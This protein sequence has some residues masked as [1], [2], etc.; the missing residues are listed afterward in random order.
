MTIFTQYRV[1]SP[2]L[3]ELDAAAGDA[4]RASF[5]QSFQANPWFAIGRWAELR[6]A[7][8]M[9]RGDFANREEFDRWDPLREQLAE[10]G[11]TA[12]E[13]PSPISAEDARRQVSELGLDL[14]I[15]EEGIYQNV[16]DI[17]IERKRAERRRLDV[18]NRAPAGLGNASARL[19]VGLG[20]SLLDPLNIASGFIPVVGPARYAAL[21]G[22]AGNV[23]SRAGVRAGVGV[24]EGTVGAALV[25]PI[26]YGAMRAEQSDYDLVDSLLNIT[27]GGVLGGGLHVVGGTVMDIRA[28]RRAAD[29]PPPSPIERGVEAAAPE[30]REAGLRT[31][32]AQMATGRNVNVEPV[33]NLDPVVRASQSEAPVLGIAR[34]LPDGT[35]VTGRGVH[36]DLITESEMDA[37]LAEGIDWSQQMGFVT[38]EGRFLTREEAANWVKENDAVRGERISAREAKTGVKSRLES[39]NYIGEEQ[40][41]TLKEFT[42]QQREA[43]GSGV[44]FM[45]TNAQRAELARR[46]LTPDQIKQMRPADVQAALRSSAAAGPVDPKAWE[47]VN[48][49]A[50]ASADEPSALADPAAS[51]AA[52]ETLK[53]NTKADTTEGLER[54]LADILDDLK[55]V[56]EGVGNPQ[57]LDG[58]AAEAKS[59]SQEYDSLGRAGKAAAECILRRGARD[60]AGSTATAAA[61]AAAT[62]AARTTAR[63]SART[64]A[65]GVTANVDDISKQLRASFGTDQFGVLFRDL[66]Q[67]LSA[68]DAK[69]LARTFT[70]VN[71]STKREA[72]KYIEGFNQAV[73]NFERK[74]AA[75]GGRVAG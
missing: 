24:V 60:A 70:P 53:A 21:V 45:V 63:T 34:R 10:A 3:S 38:P 69:A 67:P 9:S 13:L 27:F 46:G 8:R 62:T 5:E 74:T 19:A 51:R 47:Q 66:V 52:D 72:L 18:L 23:V 30:T 48:A 41:L 29:A 35:V 64:A 68:A 50:R 32:V 61:T 55:A 44:P 39:Y 54:E 59:I 75:T 71:A 20:A 57:A 28:G 49:T 16:L 37:L 11:L 22:R 6:T 65:K 4:L 12:P 73:G 14:Q 36:S 42:A 33:M 25:E 40:G 17:L 56:A 26:V 7:E 31:G 58:I 43:S 2:L 15:P 1:R